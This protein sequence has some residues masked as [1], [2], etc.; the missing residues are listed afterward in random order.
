MIRKRS[1]KTLFILL[2][3]IVLCLSGCFKKGFE[4]KTISFAE[5]PLEVTVGE[6]KSIGYALQEIDADIKISARCDSDILSVSMDSN[7]LILT[8]NKE[9][10]CSVTFTLA[11][12]GYKTTES[13]YKITVTKPIMFTVLADGKAVD[14]KICI[15]F[16]D[17]SNIK[18]ISTVDSAEI[19]VKALDES[20]VSVDY[21][22]GSW[23]ITPIS[24]GSTSLEISAAANGYA[25]TSVLLPV[26]ISKKEAYLSLDSDSVTSAA[27]STAALEYECQPQAKVTAYSDNQNLSLS[28]NDN[29]ILL[30]SDTAGSYNVVVKCEADNFLVS[31][32]S[33]TAVFTKPA[34]PLIAPKSYELN[35]GEKASFALAGYPEST[36]F[37]VSCGAKLDA[38]VQNGRITVYAK[39]A[40]SDYITV[41]AEKEGY[42]ATQIRIPVSIK[43]VTT[44]INRQFESNI[45]DIIRLVNSERTSR[46]LN[47]LY[48]LVELEQSTAIR[49]QEASEE[50]SHTRPDKREWHTALSDTGVKYIV[51]GENLLEINAID[52]RE[53]VNAWM[54]SPGHR[55]NILRKNFV[56]TYVGLYKSGSTY[57]YCQHFIER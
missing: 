1:V 36:V 39:A 35:S 45:K 16:G 37:S 28:I 14:Q 51:A 42:R 7:K 38:T 50:W 34:L 11:A 15:N 46:G 56:Y 21:Q 6:T 49:A 24:V 10:E 48:T 52:A 33:F 43:A 47:P 27:G 20:V 5:F 2:I 53:A 26:E 57:W 44:E 9:G 40:G 13:T 32:K 23:T 3:I 30:S 41:T 29:K 54:E 22:N 8:G 55:E 18:I 25:S 19:T 31:E 17:T 4:N 12:K